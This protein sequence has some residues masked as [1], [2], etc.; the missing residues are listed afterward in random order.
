MGV[1]GLPKPPS[2]APALLCS[3]ES[4]AFGFCL[5]SPPPTF[6][7]TRDTSGCFIR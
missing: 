5:S 1:T 6:D 4:L 3:N 7:Y 2:P